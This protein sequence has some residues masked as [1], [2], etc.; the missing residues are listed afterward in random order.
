MTL[1]SIPE[2][3]CE[4]CDPL[5]QIDVSRAL[6]VNVRVVGPLGCDLEKLLGFRVSA[7]GQ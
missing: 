1:L 4:V 6:E 5:L 7:R 2:C 3:S